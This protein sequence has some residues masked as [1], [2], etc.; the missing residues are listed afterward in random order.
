MHPS[1]DWLYHNTDWISTPLGNRTSWPDS[2]K[3]AVELILPMPISI[4]IFAGNQNVAIYNDAF[5]RSTGIIDPKSFGRPANEHWGDLWADHQPYVESVLSDRQSISAKNRPFPVGKNDV[6]S[7]VYFD[8]SYSPIVDLHGATS[9]ILCAVSEQTAGAISAGSASADARLAAIVESS[10][11]AIISKDLS[12]TITSWNASAE[13]LFGYEAHEAIGRSVTM[14]IPP[15]L[16]WQEEQII[17]RI[18]TGKRLESFETIRLRKD[19][20]RINVSLMISP[21]MGQS[22]E[23]VGAS[24]IARDISEQIEYARRI[25]FLMREMNHRVKNQYTVIL[26]MLKWA[27][28]SASGFDQFQNEFSNRI[29]SLARSHDLLMNSDRAQ[30]SLSDLVQE[31]LEPFGSSHLFSI[32]GDYIYINSKAVQ[33]LGMAIYELA[34]NSA[35]YGILL[36]GYGHISIVWEIV[37]QDNA[38]PRFQLYWREAIDDNDSKALIEEGRFDKPG[39]GS[40]VLKRIVAEA[41]EGRSTLEFSSRELIWSF[42]APLHLL[43]ERVHV[44]EPGAMVWRDKEY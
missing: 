13:R 9:G 16:L 12:G 41:L 6:P 10:N 1:S 37:H 40:I 28:K 21:V 38:R 3:A 43:T 30:V 4:V 14:L 26:S 22:G 42:N 27:A 8:A 19:G 34:T 7:P 39:F 17:S 33:N 23:V 20:T 2:T 29:L 5:A 36:R 18:R 11:D 32:S 35:K 31:Q 24:K 15:E 44:L 25:K